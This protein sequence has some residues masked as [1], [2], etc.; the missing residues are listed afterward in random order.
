MNKFEDQDIG[1]G[2][3]NN[4][5]CSNFINQTFL[6]FMLGV[7]ICAIIIIKISYKFTCNLV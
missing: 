6:V 7:I 3:G 5:C 2:M 1:I 4:I